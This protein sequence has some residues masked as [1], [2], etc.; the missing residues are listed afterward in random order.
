MIIIKIILKILLIIN[1]NISEK[2]T[3]EIFA[4][5]GTGTDGS[6]FAFG[7]IAPGGA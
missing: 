5:V 3:G 6:N 7:I 2:A 4:G 1:I